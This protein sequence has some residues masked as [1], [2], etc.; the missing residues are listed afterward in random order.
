MKIVLELSDKD[1]RYFRKCLQTVRQGEQASDEGVVLKSAAEL[2]AEVEETDTPEFVT[3]RMKKLRQLIDM[4]EDAEWRLTGPDRTRV[5][6]A[7]AYFVD[8]DDLI[9]DRIPG[10]GYLDDAIMVELVVQELAPEIDAYEKF[11]EFRETRAPTPDALAKQ[12]VSLQSRMRR[13][14]RRQRDSRRAKSSSSRSP[15]SLF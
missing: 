13:R 9:P 11:C 15:L 5:L 8:P 7:L 14:R 12:R 4:L 1:L 3:G 10:I 6:S 2:I